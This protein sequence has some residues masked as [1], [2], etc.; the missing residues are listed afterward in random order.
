MEWASA[1]YNSNYH[2]GHLPRP[3]MG[4][5]HQHWT[6][7]HDWHTWLAGLAWARGKLEDDDDLEAKLKKGGWSL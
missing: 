1:Y 4:M 6:V 7:R 3:G 2:T 5:M